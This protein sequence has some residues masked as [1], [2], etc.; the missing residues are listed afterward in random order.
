MKYGV[1]EQCKEF[2]KIKQVFSHKT[3]RYFQNQLEEYLNNRSD[4]HPAIVCW[5]EGAMNTD[6]FIVMCS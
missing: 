2:M 3:L 5:Y 4:A 1:L 6:D